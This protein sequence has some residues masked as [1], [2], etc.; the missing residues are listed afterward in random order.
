M[1]ASEQH[2]G[3]NSTSGANS[4]LWPDN[5]LRGG[6]AFRTDRPEQAQKRCRGQDRVYPC[7]CDALF[8]F[9]GAAGRKR[10]FPTG[11][12]QYSRKLPDGNRS[13][14]LVAIIR[15]RPCLMQPLDASRGTA[16][17]LCRCPGSHGPARRRDMLPVRCDWRAIPNS[18]ASD[19]HAVTSRAADGRPRTG[20]VPP[21]QE[22]LPGAALKC[23]SNL[24]ATPLKSSASAGASPL[25]VMLG[26]LS[27]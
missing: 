17:P 18:R 10:S 26:Q 13:G 19:N 3:A 8:R 25:R 22:P 4:T 11:L 6:A 5:T 12:M 7:P 16:R 15:P 20:M 21:G 2:V 1:E 14:T 24:P 23:W 9:A 27:E